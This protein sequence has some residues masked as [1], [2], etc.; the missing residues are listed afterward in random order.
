MQIAYWLHQFPEFYFGKVKRDEI[1]T[2]CV[3]IVLYLLYIGAAY[4]L[5]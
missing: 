4:S 3:Y 1:R 5:K 2:R